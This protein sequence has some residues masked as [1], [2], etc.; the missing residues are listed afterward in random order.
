MT[1]LTA[2]WLGVGMMAGAQTVHPI[3]KPDEA[4]I[5]ADAKQEKP[6]VETPNVMEVCA[7]EGDKEC[8]GVIGTTLDVHGCDTWRGFEYDP[9]TGVC[10][11]ALV[12]DKSLPDGISCSPAIKE[13]DGSKHIVCW[14]KP[15]KGR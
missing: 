2:L 3:A 8:V 4:K 1:R 10:A 14:Y 7:R 6:P 11:I 13:A 15:S 9:A 5:G 12:L